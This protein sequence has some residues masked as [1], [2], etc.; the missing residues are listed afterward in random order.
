VNSSEWSQLGYDDKLRWLRAHAFLE[1]LRHALTAMEWS[2]LRRYWHRKPAGRGPCQVC[3]C[4]A[5]RLR[6]MHRWDESRG[7]FAKYVVVAYG[8]NI[9]DSWYDPERGVW[10]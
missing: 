1:D 8:C 5:P 3:G 6:A 9:L 10:E 7:K 4:A 2:Q